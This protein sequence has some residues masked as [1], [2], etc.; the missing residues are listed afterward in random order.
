MCGGY[1]QPIEAPKEEFGLS[2]QSGWHLTGGVGDNCPRDGGLGALTHVG[3]STLRA[4]DPYRARAAECA[5]KAR[6]ACSDSVRTEWESL[7]RAYRSLADH[8]DVSERLP[9]ATSA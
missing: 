5:A 2:N 1:C 8:A 9:F 6:E 3:I 7:A 4:G